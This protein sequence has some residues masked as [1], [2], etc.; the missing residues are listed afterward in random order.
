[1]VYYLQHRSCRIN[2][3]APAEKC[4]APVTVV[5]AD[6][7][8]SPS[9][10]INNVSVLMFSVP[11]VPQEGMELRPSMAHRNFSLHGGS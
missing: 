5:H 2:G 4:T 11:M 9:A 1:M 6:G 7:N 8:S 10:L 3:V